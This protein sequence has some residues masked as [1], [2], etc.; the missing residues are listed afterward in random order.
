M[1]DFKMFVDGLQFFCDTCIFQFRYGEHGRPEESQAP[2]LHG[3]ARHLPH[4][5]K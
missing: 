2:H 5:D 3:F 1:P 4:R